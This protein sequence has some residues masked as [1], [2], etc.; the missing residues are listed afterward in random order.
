MDP[1]AIPAI[2]TFLECIFDLAS[3]DYISISRFF[4]LKAGMSFFVVV[5]YVVSIFGFLG[6]NLS[7]FT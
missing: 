5:F 2:L 7:F 4:F 1:S 6:D 3:G